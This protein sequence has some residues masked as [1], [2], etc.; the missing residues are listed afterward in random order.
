MSLDDPW[1]TGKRR[2]QPRITRKDTQPAASS[3]MSRTPVFQGILGGM[4]HAVVIRLFPEPWPGF[5]PGADEDAEPDA[6]DIDAEMYNC[7]EDA[8]PMDLFDVDV[9]MTGI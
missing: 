6:M 3:D 8:E 1:S 2:S 5:Q 9:Q 4:N 7:W